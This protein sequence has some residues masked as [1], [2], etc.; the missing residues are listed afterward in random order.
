MRAIFLIAFSLFTLFASAQEMYNAKKNKIRSVTYCH[1]ECDTSYG[2]YTPQMDDSL[3]EIYNRNGI[4]TRLMEISY[5]PECDA[6]ISHCNCDRSGRLSRCKSSGSA[7]KFITYYH[8]DERGNKVSEEEWE[9][10]R[11]KRAYMTAHEMYDQQGRKLLV[12]FAIGD[13]P[14]D[15]LE[16]YEYKN[17]QLILRKT[18]TSEIHYFYDAHDSLIREQGHTQYQPFYRFLYLRDPAGYVYRTEEYEGDTLHAFTIFERD[19]AK[20]IIR[21]TET[22]LIY[23]HTWTKEFDEKGRCTK[24]AVDG[25]TREEKTW[26]AFGRPLV[27]RYYYIDE[28]TY[29]ETKYT[30]N[31]KGDCTGS[32]TV[33]SNGKLT[34][35][36]TY[37]YVYFD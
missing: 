15:T 14:A 19:T 20:R 9:T 30:Y 11:G 7:G 4:R 25:K 23:H 18:H 5:E 8:Y 10:S 37:R 35:C 13:Q 12:T 24:E 1:Y 33:A 31:E 28:G 36:E 34:A 26:D 2:N 27:S 6:S 21:T 29:S 17:A 22:S 16:Y 3:T 32:R